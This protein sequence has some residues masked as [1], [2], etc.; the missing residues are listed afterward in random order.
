MGESDPQATPAADDTMTLLARAR[1]GDRLALNV[2]FERQLPVLRRWAAGRLPRWARQGVDTSDVV[3]ETVIASLGRLD[4]FEPRGEGALQGYLRRAVINA[5]R[6]LIRKANARPEIVP[7]DA[8]IV[9]G[10]PS[11]LEA[12]MGTQMLA[13]YDSALTRLP[14]AD[15]DAIVGRIEFGMS[16]GEL[17]ELLDKP[18][19]DAARMTV[20]RAIVKLT[21]EM[22]AQSHSNAFAQQ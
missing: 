5:I 14:A 3:Q 18:S 16:Y 17:A 6:S 21:R 11:V 8:A 13:V 4:N 9:D 7:I 10:G 12:A 1:S 2:L 20:K 19:A 22:H 15:R